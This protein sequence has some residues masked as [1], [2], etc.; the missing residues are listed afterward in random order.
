MKV[1]KFVL[2]TAVLVSLVLGLN[3]RVLA[4]IS[5][6][7]TGSWSETIDASDLQAGAGSDLN[8]TYE[9]GSSQVSIDISGTA[10]GGDDWRVDV[11]KVDTIWHGNL[12]L[13]V[14]R[15]SAGTGGSVSGG[16]FYQ[17]VG[18]TDSSF[19]NGSDDVSGIEVQLQLTGVS[20][21][22]PPNTYTTTVTYTVVD[23]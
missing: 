15:T 16:T 10:G 1:W 19:F 2:V 23:T 4:V 8:S 14:K 7:V 6:T 5:I 11:K 20:V 3:G 12:T 13:W 9:S 21:S 18:G 17:P 22:V